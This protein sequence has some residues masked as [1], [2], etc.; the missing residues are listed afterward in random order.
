MKWGK[1]FN[2]PDDREDL[3]EIAV[4]L[5]SQIRYKPTEAFQKLYDFWE[6][7][8]SR[9]LWELGFYEDY[10][11]CGHVV[12]EAASRLQNNAI[13]AQ[14]L[15][16]MGYCFMEKE[17]P[18]DAK[19][20]FEKSLDILSVLGNEL[21]ICR[22]NRYLATLFYRQKEYENS[23]AYIQ[24]A[25][26]ILQIHGQEDDRWLLH[27]SA[28]KN[29]KG[30]ILAK[31]RSK[32]A[33]EYFNEAFEIARKLKK[34]GEYYEVSS[35]RNIGK[36][37]RELGEYE[38]AKYILGRT[39]LICERIA[40]TDLIASTHIE[41]S[42]LCQQTGDIKHALEH[43][44]AAIDASGKEHPAERDKAVALQ[45]QLTELLRLPARQ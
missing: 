31:R 4:G 21:G 36:F 24:E 30:S 20:C 16:E 22:V 35:Q 34:N 17:M 1:V 2:H 25:E 43:A 39:L 29:L 41:L 28:L 11:R 42:K 27:A 6:T 14:L 3:Y 12:L 23:V 45:L 5:S 26:A 37:Y 19:A 9:P 44:V 40:R 7:K 10:L 32:T 15:N 38:K 33:L 8:I 13:E 18:E